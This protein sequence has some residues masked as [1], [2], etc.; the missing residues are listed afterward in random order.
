MRLV[1]MDDK[2]LSQSIDRFTFLKDD[3]LKILKKNNVKTLGQLSNKTRTDLKHY[4]FEKY[5][6]DKIDIELQLLGLGLKVS[7]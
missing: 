3:R 6:I 5:E 7:N 2:Y 1:K 4:G